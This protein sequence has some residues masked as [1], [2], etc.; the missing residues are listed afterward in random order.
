MRGGGRYTRDDDDVEGALEDGGTGEESGWKLVHGDVFRP[1]RHPELLSALIGTGACTSGASIVH[2]LPA[3]SFVLNCM[4]P[5]LHVGASTLARI[6]CIS[7]S[8]NHVRYNVMLLRRK[9]AA[10]T[11]GTYQGRRGSWNE[12]K[13]NIGHHG[14]LG[15]SKWLQARYRCGRGRRGA[16][17]NAGAVRGADHHSRHAV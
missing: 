7:S 14:R 5:S 15:V 8:L 6:M 4:K 9:I 3:Q 16:I 17:G 12:H 1:P 2:V 11:S 13:R 10:S